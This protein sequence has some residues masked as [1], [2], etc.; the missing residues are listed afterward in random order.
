MKLKKPFLLI[1]VIVLL[2]TCAFAWALTSTD[3]VVTIQNGRSVRATVA[4]VTAAGNAASDP[5]VTKSLSV[6]EG[7]IT[8][9]DTV[10]GNNA[11]LKN[12]IIGLPRVTLTRLGTG[13]NGAA[14]AHS[15]ILMDDTPTGEWSAVDAG[16]TVTADTTYFKLGVNSLKT[17]FKTTATVA[18]GVTRTTS[19]ID[20]STDTSIGL[21]VYSTKVLVAGD[22]VLKITDSVAGVT[23]VN[24]PAVAT[25]NKWTW[26]ELDI[27]GV[28]STSRDV[29]NTLS[30]TLSAAGVVKSTAGAFS[31]YADQ[32]TAWAVGDEISLGSSIIQDGVLGVMGLTYTTQTV[33]T[34]ASLVGENLPL[35]LNTTTGTGLATLSGATLVEGTNYLIAYRSGVDSLVCI[36]DLSKTI[37]ST[38]VAY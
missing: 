5:M 8:V 36:T 18:S 13:T 28:T 34:A 32:M 10:N 22:I 19:S 23:S 20:L 1:G 21:W 4:A 15:Q 35:T 7:D 26:V 24:I 11:G 9:A 27:S 29:V 14:S 33:L 37:M 31:V 38:F 2:L 17:L 3:S 6:T 30:I 25:A 12:E 16:S